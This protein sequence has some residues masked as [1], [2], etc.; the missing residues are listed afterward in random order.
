MLLGYAVYLVLTVI[1]G[2]PWWM[3]FRG[4][5]RFFLVLWATITIPP[6]IGAAALTAASLSS[7]KWETRVQRVI[8]FN[9]VALVVLV[10]W[11]WT[12]NSTFAGI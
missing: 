12:V 1:V 11:A 8:V 10:L 4:P 2:I 6:G 5:F 7:G 3:S 9:A